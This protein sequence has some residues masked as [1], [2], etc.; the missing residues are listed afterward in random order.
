[1][2][3]VDKY[4]TEAKIKL[5]TNDIKTLIKKGKSGKYDVDGKTVMVKSI[6]GTTI[7]EYSADMLDFTYKLTQAADDLGYDYQQIGLGKKK[8]I[9]FII[10]LS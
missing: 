1:M 4:L 8:N 10:D 5:N 2:N 9:K 6:G 3:V 7:L